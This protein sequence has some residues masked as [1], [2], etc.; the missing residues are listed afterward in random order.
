MAAAVWINFDIWDNGWDIITLLLILH[1]DRTIIE[2]KDKTTQKNEDDLFD[3]KWCIVMFP[4]IIMF[5]LLIVGL[6][7]VDLRP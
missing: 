7:L 1:L 3:S 6:H 5:S 4:I 2:T